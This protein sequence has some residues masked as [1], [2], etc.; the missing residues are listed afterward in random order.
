MKQHERP[1]PPEAKHHGLHGHL[2]N[3]GAWL[4]S[5][6]RVVVVLLW[7]RDDQLKIELPWIVVDVDGSPYVNVGYQLR[8]ESR[9]QV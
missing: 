9:M 6:I 2:P 8:G 7:Q 3:V 5:T 4:P 1:N